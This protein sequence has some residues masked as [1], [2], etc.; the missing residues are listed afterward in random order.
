M[1]CLRYWVETMQVDGFRFDL[2]PVLGR[3]QQGFDQGSGFF[4]A[5]LQDPAL[6]G[7]K[8]IAEPWDIGPGG[9]QLGNFPAGWSE[10]N[11]RYRDTVRRF[12]KGDSG[13][14][15]DLARR[16]HGSS[17]VFE[18]S[19]RRPSASI[20]FV[21]SHDG[22]TLADLVAYRDRHNQLNKE[23]NK[24]GHR[25]NYSDNFGVEGPTDDASINILRWR[26]QRNLLASCIVF[27]G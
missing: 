22:F 19:G 8:F 4:D 5:I 21:T 16:I 27:P 1:D 10:W 18:H 25:E 6:A 17:D 13:V 11:D 15:P 23:D 9:Y 20:N 14:L 26:Q 12:W 3:E 2:A 24:D 7:T